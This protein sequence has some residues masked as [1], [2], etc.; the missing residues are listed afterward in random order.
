MQVTGEVCWI[1]GITTV[2]VA[3]C[4]SSLATWQLGLAAGLLNAMHVLKILYKSA[5][6]DSRL[7][8][9]DNL[10]YSLAEIISET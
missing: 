1:T 7:T 2:I 4:L 10:C 9:F 3:N 8:I 6:D 5:C